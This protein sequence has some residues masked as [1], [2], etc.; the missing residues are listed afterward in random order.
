MEDIVTVNLFDVA[1][2]ASIRTAANVAL[3]KIERE[4]TRNCAVARKR[5]GKDNFAFRKVISWSRTTLVT[6][7]VFDVYIAKVG[8]TQHMHNT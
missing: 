7:L 4:T 5:L 2:A 6:I 3:D 1:A 8:Y